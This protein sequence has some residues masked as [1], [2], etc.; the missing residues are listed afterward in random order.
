[1]CLRV[2]CVMHRLERVTN[3]NVI[4]QTYDYIDL[5]ILKRFGYLKHM[6]EVCLIKGARE[7][8]VEDAI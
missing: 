5:W 6:G 8:N 2:V 7:F 4:V 1:M 3:K